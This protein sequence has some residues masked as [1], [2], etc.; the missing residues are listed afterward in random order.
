MDNAVYGHWESRGCPGDKEV[1]FPQVMGTERRSGA[2]LSTERSNLAISSTYRGSVRW[3]RDAAF[4][5]IPHYPHPY[6]YGGTFL[7]I[8]VSPNST[9]ETEGRVAPG[10]YEPDRNKGGHRDAPVSSAR[11]RLHLHG[12]TS[13]SWLIS[14]RSRIGRY[15]RP[16]R[17][18]RN[19]LIARKNRCADRDRTYCRFWPGGQRTDRVGIRWGVG[20]PGPRTASRC[21]RM[22]GAAR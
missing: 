14:D 22:G 9:K 15:H 2:E 1:G 10:D 7:L 18:I 4:R 8:S 21:R 16:S 3:R 5:A 12:H 17:S 6:N 13:Q 20:M 19:N 11:S